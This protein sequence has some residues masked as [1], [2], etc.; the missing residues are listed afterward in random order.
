MAA[1]TEVDTANKELAY[2]TL[3]IAQFDTASDGDTYDCKKLA[4]VDAVFTAQTTTDSIETG[5]SSTIQ[6]NG[7]PRITLGLSADCS[8]YVVVV[9][10]K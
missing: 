3:E 9:G 1:I 2:P 7:Q 10:R 8:G 4:Q 6:S 5:A